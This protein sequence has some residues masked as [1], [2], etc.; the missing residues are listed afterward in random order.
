MDVRSSESL[1]A[2]YFLPFHR[3]IFSFFF[4]QP[5]TKNQ[6]REVFVV[7]SKLRWD[8]HL[9]WLSSG[10][11]PTTRGHF[12]GTSRLNGA[13]LDGGSRAVVEP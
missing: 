5:E 1:I 13:Q 2:L 11:Q 10:T 3:L 6:E 12:T 4:V 8:I 9:Q 7:V